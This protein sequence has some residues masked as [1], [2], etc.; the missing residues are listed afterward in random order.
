MKKIMIFAASALLAM[1][2]MA[3][4]S[5]YNHNLQ[6]TV[7]GGMNTML[8]KPSDGKA[9]VG[10]GALLQAKYEYMFNEHWGIGAGLGFSS[11]H[12]SA[13][14]NNQNLEMDKLVHPDNNEPYTP[15][16]SFNKLKEAQDMITIDIPVQA[17]WR[18]QLTN[19]WGLEAG[20]G[21]SFNIPVWMQYQPRKGSY[22]VTGYFESVHGFITNL[23]NHGLGTVEPREKGK[24]AHKAMNLGFQGDFGAN[25]FLRDNMA[26]YMGLYLDAQ[27]LNAISQSEAEHVD[28][29][30]RQYINTMNTKYVAAVHPFE[31]G[32]K[33]GLTFGLGEKKPT[34]TYLAEQQRLAEEEA[35]RLA[36]EKAEEERLAREAAEKAEQE[37]I[38][39]EKAER[40]AAEKAAAEQKAADEQ[41]RKEMIA[42][43]QGGVNFKSGSVEPIFTEEAKQALENLKDYLE[44]N[45]EMNIYITGHTDNVGNAAKNMVYGQRRADAYKAAIV[46]KGIEETRIFTDSKGQTEPIADN[47]TE[48]GRAKNRRAEMN[49]H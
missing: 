12:S 22:N 37:R 20:L 31:F 42:A 47:A 23:P 17:I 16:L 25:Y 11:Y 39:R 21:L 33:V 14:F 29:N 4:D 45:P 3:Q 46:K 28:V 43:I 35:A 1:S 24:V 10:G 19:A 40:E 32:V 13:V 48:E 15:Y 44:Q 18:H 36:A 49:I 6:V 26:L 38:A 8:Y 5:I 2:A 30:N 27:M 34:K 9:R 41:K 7:G